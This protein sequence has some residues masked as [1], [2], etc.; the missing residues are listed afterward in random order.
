MQ[1]GATACRLY[2]AG[3]GALVK[4]SFGMTSSENPAAEVGEAGEGG[5]LVGL[6]VA[7]TTCAQRMGLRPTTVDPLSE[8]KLMRPER[9]R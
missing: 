6:A 9:V 4:M 5:G 1:S 3:P 8:A 2:A 7:P